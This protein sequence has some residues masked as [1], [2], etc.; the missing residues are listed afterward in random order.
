MLYDYV[1]AE[2]PGSIIKIAKQGMTIALIL[3][4]LQ[5]QALRSPVLRKNLENSSLQHVGKM[6]VFTLTCQ[7]VMN[8]RK[9]IANSK[10]IPKKT[11]A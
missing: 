8:N 10:A 9:A 5:R 11:L 2:F 1:W 7:D 3:H 4:E 6:W